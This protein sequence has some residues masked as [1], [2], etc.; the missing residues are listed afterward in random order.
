MYNNFV[1]SGYPGIKLKPEYDKLFKG[2][3]LPKYV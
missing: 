1:K 3:M 2:L